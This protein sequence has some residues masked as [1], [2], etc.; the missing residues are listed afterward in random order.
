MRVEAQDAPEHRVRL[1]INLTQPIVRTEYAKLLKNRPITDCIARSPDKSDLDAARV[2]DK[3][4]NRYAEKQFNMPKIRR[5]AVM[6]A[7]TCG[8]GAIFVDYDDTMLGE[9]DVLVDP[10]GNPI[11]DPQVIKAVQRQWK[12]K[13]KAP[14]TT[15]IPNGDL[16]PRALGPM[17]WGWDFSTSDPNQAQWQYVSE[18]YDVCEVKRRWG[19][20]VEV[21]DNVRPNVLEQRI[22]ERADLTNTFRNQ[23]F[24][25]TSQDLVVV[26]RLFIKPGHHYFPDGAEIVFTDDKLIDATKFPWQHGLLP[27][28]AMG[29]IPFPGSR[30]PLSILSQIRDPV[31]EISKTES[32]MLENRNLMGNPPWIAYDYHNLPEIV[33]KP[34][35][36]ITIPW[37]PNGSDPHPVEMPEMPAYIQDLPNRIREYVQDIAGQGETS[38]GRVP[39]GARSGVAI[40]YLQEED[41]TKLGPTVSE[42]E[43]MIEGVDWRV[44]RLFAEKYEL[45][46]MVTI[47]RKHSDPEVINFVGTMLAGVTGV[48]VQAGS[49]L[50]R[51]KAA[52]QQYILDLFSMGIEQDP[53]KVKDMLELGEGDPEDW[54]RDMQQ[55]ERENERMEKGQQANVKDWYNHQAHI[56]T[57][58]KFMK[59][60]DY[61]ALPPEMQKI[62]EDHDALH[63]KFLTGV[64]AAQQQ[65]VP[66]PG[67]SIPQAAV[68]NGQ[69]NQAPV[70]GGPPAT[71]GQAPPSQ[72]D[73][74]PQ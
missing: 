18:T 35:L 44:L 51:S 5:E 65:G 24:S 67:Q 49:G 27:V 8:L 26:H 13:K 30:Y 42:L 40:A 25:P 60:A 56:V 37:R 41:D 54:E 20:E 23:H 28:V 1:S 29:H 43:E 52:K 57:H 58:R 70:E 48:E 19:V 6:W 61:E 38:Q 4:L 2:G 68:D 12:A 50:P 72:L 31:L 55:A 9:I 36:Q 64:A 17:Q 10:G 21:N 34:G 46:R 32:Q 16:R 66:V 11:F 63:Q 45:P 69:N 71:N 3:M 53:R 59:S 22:L 7:L 47:N 14:K 39:P 33:N 62:F 73:Y 15:K 74:Q